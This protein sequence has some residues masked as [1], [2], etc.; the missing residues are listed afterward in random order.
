MRYGVPISLPVCRSHWTGLCLRSWARSPP[1]PEWTPP[2]RKPFSSGSVSWFL[3]NAEISS[4]RSNGAIFPVFYGYKGLTIRRFKIRSLSSQ[5]G[6]T[7]FLYRRL[8][9]YM[10][11]LGLKCCLYITLRAVDFKSQGGFSWGLWGRC[12][13]LSFIQ[14]E[15]LGVPSMGWAHEILSSFSWQEVEEVGVRQECAKQADFP[16]PGNPKRERVFGFGVRHVGSSQW[17]KEGLP[18]AQGIR[19]LTAQESQGAVWDMQAPETP[20]WRPCPLCQMS[21]G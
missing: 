13:C 9:L 15:Y 6:E 3:G 18:W 17:G 14:A 21:A 16:Y 19:G 11:T 2:Q 7:G 20:D 4:A 5:P 10:K 1:I 12:L 8:L